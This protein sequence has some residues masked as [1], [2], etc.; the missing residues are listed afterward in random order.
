MGGSMPHERTIVAAFEILD[1]FII[2]DVV[3]RNGRIEM[4]SDQ[5]SRI[6]RLCVYSTHVTCRFVC[7][8]LVIIFGHVV[9]LE[10]MDG[11]SLSVSPGC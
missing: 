2:L 5:T 7:F 3:W 11:M 8:V 1:V 6:C 10:V 9:Q 4:I